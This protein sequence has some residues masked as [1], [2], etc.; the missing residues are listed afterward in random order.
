MV[1]RSGPDTTSKL[2]Q[3]LAHCGQEQLTGDLQICSPNYQWILRCERGAL[4]GD[5]GGIHPL[6]RWRRQLSQHCPQW[7][8]EL[9]LRPE[10]SLHQWPGCFLD[11]LMAWD[12]FSSPQVLFI[13]EG[14]LR[15]VLFDCI[16]IEARL[17]REVG[18]DLRVSWATRQPMPRGRETGAVWS[19]LRADELARGALDQWQSWGRA[20][21]QGISPNLA[22]V[23]RQASCLRG[24]MSA[25]V[26]RKLAQMIDGHRTLRDLAVKLGQDVLTLSQSLKPL[27]RQGSLQ[28]AQ[29]PDLDMEVPPVTEITHYPTPEL[30]LPQQLPASQNQISPLIAYINSRCINGQLLQQIVQ[31]AGYR[32]LNIHDPLQMLP[33]L[34][35]HCPDLILLDVVLPITS[36]YEICAQ[37]QGIPQLHS[38]PIILIASQPTLVD[39]ARAREAGAADV[40]IRP[41]T[42]DTIRHLLSRHALRLQVTPSPQTARTGAEL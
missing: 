19:D 30:R 26:F 9:P 6:R 25:P 41:I 16:Q 42:V 13:V 34:I 20:Q 2:L 11:Q 8:Q 3:R 23:I 14:S 18:Q 39:R 35:Q 10:H 4:V 5:Q 22:P 29:V 33:S 7:G 37:I 1:Q 27:L 17:Q 38:I 24:P 21:L 40:I 31:Q 28:L 36:G 12:L 32:Y 15:E